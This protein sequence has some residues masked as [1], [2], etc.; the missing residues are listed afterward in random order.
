VHQWPPRRGSYLPGLHALFGEGGAE[1]LAM[2]CR[3][4][5]SDPVFIPYDRLQRARVSLAPE[6]DWRSFV[7]QYSL[8]R[9]P[10]YR[11]EDLLPRGH[12][13]VRRR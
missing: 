10:G 7:A 4:F 9:P 5:V 6:V 13:K 11:E 8:E 12:C 2:G 1:Y 3:G